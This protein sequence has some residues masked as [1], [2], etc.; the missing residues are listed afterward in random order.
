MSNAFQSFIHNEG[1]ISQRFCPSTQ[2]QNGVA[3]RKNCHLLD[4]VR[5]F[6]LECYGTPPFLY[7]TL[8]ITVHLINRSSSLTLHNVS[9]FYKLCRNSPS[10]FY[11]CTFG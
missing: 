6:F 8:S 5:T 3:K 9:L 4:V 7:E 1:I 10:F 2:Q 11:H